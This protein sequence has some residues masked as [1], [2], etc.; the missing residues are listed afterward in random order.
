MTTPVPGKNPQS[1][2]AVA[3]VSD[4]LPAKN[5]VCTPAVKGCPLLMV[6]NTDL[7]KPVILA[8]CRQV[9]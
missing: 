7:G 4:K 5:I 9:S 6:D 2:A 1:L 8:V 3:F